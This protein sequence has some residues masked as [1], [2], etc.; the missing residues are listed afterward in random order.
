[1]Y[2]KFR[3][4][5]NPAMLLTVQDDGYPGACHQALDEGWMRTGEDFCELM[6]FCFLI[7]VL[8]TPVCP[9]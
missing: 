7:W 2:L 3:I 6:T 8:V 9:R 1:M 4:G 5:W